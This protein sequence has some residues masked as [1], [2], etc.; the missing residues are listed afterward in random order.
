MR[1]WWFY[2]P[3]VIDIISRDFT[4]STAVWAMPYAI[5]DT[6]TGVH[7]NQD[8]IWLLK[9]WEYI[10][11]YF[12]IRSWLL[13]SSVIRDSQVLLPLNDLLPCTGYIANK[14]VDFGLGQLIII[15]QYSRRRKKW[16]SSGN[17][18][19]YR[20]P[21]RRIKTCNLVYRRVGASYFSGSFLEPKCDFW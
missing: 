10:R 6:I 18:N 8:Q 17:D 15:F 2:G 19:M 5:P 21:R 3:A 14:G 16:L 13:W 9:I 12:H 20:A 11:F 7:S 1:T 4:R